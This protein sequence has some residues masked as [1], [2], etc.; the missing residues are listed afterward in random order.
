MSDGWG[1]ID[2][3]WLGAWELGSWPLIVRWGKMIVARLLARICCHAWLELAAR[4]R[5]RRMGRR[6][7]P[8]RN[9]R[10]TCSW[11]PICSLIWG[12]DWWGPPAAGSPW[13]GDRMAPHRY[14]SRKPPAPLY[15]TPLEKMGFWGSHGCP[16]SAVR[17]NGEAARR[18]SQLTAWERISLSSSGS[19]DTATAVG[20]EAP[21]EGDGAPYRC[22]D[23]ARAL[24]HMH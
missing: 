6:P 14:P 19:P 2:M 15:R 9:R 23:G 22:S 3:G 17:R 7:L 12:R 1:N 5:R 4:R 21:I 24:V 10:R 11:T 18:P 8:I 16:T 13:R 20:E